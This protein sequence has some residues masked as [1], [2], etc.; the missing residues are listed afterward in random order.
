[1]GIASRF[2]GFFDKVLIDAPCSGEGM[3]RKDNKLIKAW[4]KNGRSSIR[5]FRGTSFLP[6]LIC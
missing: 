5:R 6:V 4:E 1:M 3:F 2:S